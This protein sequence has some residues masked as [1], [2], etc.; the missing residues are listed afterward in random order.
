MEL[1]LIH[2]N[3]F[4]QEERPSLRRLS[5][6]VWGKDDQ[7]ILE[8][9]PF[10][11]LTW[12]LGPTW[13]V[14]GREDGEVVTFVGITERDLFVDGR[15]MK[16]GGLTSVMTHPDYRRRGFATAAVQR[17]MDFMW[18]EMGAGIGVIIAAHAA[19][20]LY[21]PLGWRCIEGT[22]TCEQPEGLFNFTEVYP[23]EPGMVVFPP[24]SDAPAVRDV[25]LN[26]LPW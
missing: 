4:P 8:R 25:D 6:A 20:P 16:A 3:G 2:S 13:M 26:G 7:E 11:R 9:Y 22:L 18:Q 19:I 24:G 10:M 17:A 15:P 1:E 12:V 5:V 23:G 14:V 21:E